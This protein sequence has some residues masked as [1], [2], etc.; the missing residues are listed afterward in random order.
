MAGITPVPDKTLRA[1]VE[2]LRPARRE[3]RR[4]P[5]RPHPG[6]VP[7]V[8]HTQGGITVAGVGETPFI[9][10]DLGRRSARDV[11]GHQKERRG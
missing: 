2:R 7:T 10:P 5:A 11:V 4:P 9:Q 8:G 3:I 6:A 1:R